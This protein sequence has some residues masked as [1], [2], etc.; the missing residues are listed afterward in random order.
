[1]VRQ[2]YDMLTDPK[3]KGVPVGGNEKIGFICAL[4]LVPDFD[5][6]ATFFGSP[7]SLKGYNDW[8]QALDGICYCD[9]PVFWVDDY[10]S[11]CLGL[12]YKSD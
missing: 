12:I 7:T 2:R 10:K 8:F 3:V 11:C 4:K 1:M 6:N 5:K 9:M